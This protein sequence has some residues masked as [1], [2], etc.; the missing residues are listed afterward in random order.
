MTTFQALG[1]LFFGSAITAVVFALAMQFAK[2]EFGK[3]NMIYIAITFG[4]MGVF[5]MAL[6]AYTA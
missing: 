6:A 2:T 5:C 4:I 3:E 1:I